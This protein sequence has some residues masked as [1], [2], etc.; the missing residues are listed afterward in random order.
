MENVGKIQQG[1][2]LNLAGSHVVIV[3]RVNSDGTYEITEETPPEIKR[4]TYTASSLVSKYSSYTIY[5]YNK[6]DSVSAPPAIEP[7]ID[8]GTNFYATIEH[9]STGL[10]LTNQDHN[11]VGN[12][13]SGAKDQVWRFERQS[14]GA[15]M[16]QSA[17]DNSVMDVS[18]CADE[19]G[20]NIYTYSEYVG[21]LNQQFYIDYRYDAYYFRPAHSDSRMMDMSLSDHNV[22]LW[23][24]GDDWE[25]QEFNINIISYI[26]TADPVDIGTDFYATIEHQT[27]GLMMTNQ[28][29]NLIGNEKS[30]TKNQVW[31]FERQT[32]GAYKIVNAYDNSVIDV[33]SCADEDG[34]NIYT[35]SEYV[36]GLNQQF[37]IYYLFDAYYFRPAHSYSRMIDLSLSDHNVSLWVKG[38][39]WEPQEFNIEKISYKITANPLDMGSVFYGQI[40]S[41]SNPRHEV[42]QCSDRQRPERA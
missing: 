12:E 16:I 10:L 42:A 27:T 31:K 2:A 22:S 29:H 5:R 8:I 30:G 24:K 39:D 18:G 36:G 14:N 33:S 19:D 17:S 13:K 23:G 15:Y 41:R 6:R 11:V 4:S 25:P 20:A 21:G 40:R 3:S 35:Y 34:T 1:D 28:E 38:D 9:Q 7:Y 32:N 26:I 37:Y